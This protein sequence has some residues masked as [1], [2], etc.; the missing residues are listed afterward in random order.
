MAARKPRI[1]TVLQATHLA[2]FL[3]GISAVTLLHIRTSDFLDQLRLPTFLKE[4]DSFLG[5]AYPASLHVYQIILL[6]TLLL[7]AIDSLGLLFYKSKIWKFMSDITSF[8]GLLV[9]WPAALFFIFTLASAQNLT[10]ASI[11]TIIVYFTFTLFI[12][13]LDLVTWFVDEQ[14]LIKIGRR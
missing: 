12:F 8:L 9:I 13:V 3:I 7:A 11:Q 6:F 1:I 10:Q 4:I 2:I 14:S 5:F